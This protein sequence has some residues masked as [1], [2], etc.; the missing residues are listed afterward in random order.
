MPMPCASK[1]PKE[2]FDVTSRRDFA[3]VTGNWSLIVSAGAVDDKQPFARANC[4]TSRR[5]HC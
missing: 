2:T 3:I 1:S 5:S 4:H